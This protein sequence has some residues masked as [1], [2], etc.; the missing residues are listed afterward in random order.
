[1]RFNSPPNWPAA[2]PGWTPP[3]DWRPDPTWP[4]P[5]PGWQLWVDDTPPSNKKGLII[6]LIAAALVVIIG[7]VL[8]ISIFTKGTPEVTVTKPV[9]TDEQQIKDVVEKY[10]TAWNDS[11]FDGFKPIACE[12][13]QKDD[14]F[15]ERDFL[16]AREGADDL[17]LQVTDVQVKKD[18]ATATVENA[19]N[20]PDDIE[21]TREDGEW[22]WCDF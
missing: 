4:P 12:D 9:K 16:D 1:M 8:A 11:N 7:A 5:P 6:G 3:P 20:D 17:H 22:K 10:E 19:G 2:P 18:K 15:N 21:F 13:W 14:V